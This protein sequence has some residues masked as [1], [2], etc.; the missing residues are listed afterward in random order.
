[1]GNFNFAAMAVPP[2]LVVAEP[3]RVGAAGGRF[4]MPD[5]RENADSYCGSVPR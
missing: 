1:M 3:A 2:P 4:V 5:D